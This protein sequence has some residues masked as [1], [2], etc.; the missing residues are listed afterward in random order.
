VRSART[1]PREVIEGLEQRQHVIAR[2]SVA[3]SS[4]CVDADTRGAQMRPAPC[5]NRALRVNRNT[6]PTRVG[7]APSPMWRGVAWRR[8]TLPYFVQKAQTK[9]PQRAKSSKST[10]GAEIARRSAGVREHIPNA[11]RREVVARDGLRCTFVSEHGCQC[12][13][14]WFITSSLGQRAATPR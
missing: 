14:S 2:D 10:G 4:P 12:T 13:A 1:T 5:R 7:P 6:T 11:T 9:S 8:R 3:N